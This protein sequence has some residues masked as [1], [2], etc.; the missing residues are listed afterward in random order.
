MEKISITAGWIFSGLGGR[1]IFYWAVGKVELQR[2][3]G[4][5]RWELEE[6]L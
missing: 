1:W 6:G 5:G 4:E 3:K 2:G